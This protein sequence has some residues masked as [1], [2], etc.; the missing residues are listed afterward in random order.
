MEDQ[1]SAEVIQKD[2]IK[3]NEDEI[4]SLQASKAKIEQTSVRTVC[5]LA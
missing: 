5:Y 2:L 4:K 3:A 1:E